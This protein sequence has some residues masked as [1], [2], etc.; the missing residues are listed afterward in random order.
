MKN[1]KLSH[2]FECSLYYYF[3][4][5]NDLNTICLNHLMIISSFHNNLIHVEVCKESLN[6]L[7]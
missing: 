5:S 3:P 4:V 2:Y 7:I 6:L 1:R